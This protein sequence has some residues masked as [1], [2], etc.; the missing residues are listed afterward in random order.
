MLSF[1]LGVLRLNWGEKEQKEKSP[2]KIR[3][4]NFKKYT[5]EN[6]R[7]YKCYGSNKYRKCSQ[8]V[9]GVALLRDWHLRGG[10][11]GGK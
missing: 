7:R 11:R 4:Y 5:I 1:I 3:I 8:I 2:L 9:L 10:A 6:V